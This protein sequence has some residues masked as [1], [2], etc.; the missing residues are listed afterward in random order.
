MYKIQIHIY[1][2]LSERCMEKK[3]HNLKSSGNPWSHP[4]SQ[5]SPS[6]VEKLWILVQRYHFWSHVSFYFWYVILLLHPTQRIQK[7]KA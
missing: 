7:K 1:W 6:Q 3:M 4:S 5:L 2:K